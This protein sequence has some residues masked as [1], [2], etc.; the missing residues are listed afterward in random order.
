MH[1]LAKN[2]EE[3]PVELTLKIL[4]THKVIITLSAIFQP[5]SH[6]NLVSYG[7]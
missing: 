2:H 5:F 3:F 4:K 7:V 1:S 6:L